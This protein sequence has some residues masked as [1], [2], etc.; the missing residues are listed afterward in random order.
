MLVV[1]VYHTQL[2]SVRVAAYAAE[3]RDAMNDAVD[4]AHHHNEEHNKER[5]QVPPVADEVI[6]VVEELPRGT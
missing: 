2:C 3:A 5:H 6:E 4:E 1:A